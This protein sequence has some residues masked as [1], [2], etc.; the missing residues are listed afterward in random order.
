MAAGHM[1]AP[2][3]QDCCPPSSGFPS[4]VEPKGER[5]RQSS[6]GQADPEARENAIAVTRRYSL[7]PH[8]N[9]PSC[10]SHGEPVLP[11]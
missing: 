8:A 4:Q 5:T 11:Q 1:R 6:G 9:L 7:L 2:A 10:S 3:V